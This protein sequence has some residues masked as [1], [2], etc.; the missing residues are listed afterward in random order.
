M[1]NYVATSRTNYFG[2]K[3]RAAFFEELKMYSFEDIEVFEASDDSDKIAIAGYCD[4]SVGYD[5]M[6]DETVEFAELIS[7]HIKEEDACILTVSGNEKLRY[8]T[9]F[10]VAITSK[11]YHYIDAQTLALEAASKMLEVDDFQTVMAY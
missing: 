7:N 1:A 5:D 8:V 3:D 10:A 6:E 11:G 9:A 2:V 4:L